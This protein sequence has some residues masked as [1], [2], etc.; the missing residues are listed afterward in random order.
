MPV[1]TKIATHVRFRFAM[2][3]AA[4]GLGPDVRPAHQADSWKFTL[5]RSGSGSF[6]CGAC[7]SRWYQNAVL[8]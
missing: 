2:A 8:Q 4:L 7:G 1:A 5:R 6:G 3:L